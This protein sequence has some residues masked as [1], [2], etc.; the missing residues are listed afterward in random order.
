MH[1][2]KHKETLSPSYPFSHHHKMGS[3][4]LGEVHRLCIPHPISATWI[5]LS[6]PR[7]P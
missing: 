7:I 2:E 6:Q 4:M 5:Q 1:K 3:E